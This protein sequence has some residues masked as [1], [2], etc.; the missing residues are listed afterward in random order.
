MLSII[1]VGL[2]VVVT[3]IFPVM[4]VAQKLGAEKTELI[5]CIL[6]IVVGGIVS[7][8]L[9]SFLPGSSTNEILYFLYSFLII[10][11][12]YKY[13]LQAN[14]FASV[15]IALISTLIKWAIIYVVAKILT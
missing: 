7:S 14:Y 8:I 1:I 4:F 3:S 5:D 6:A 11:V 13:M 9:V 10:G 12:V 15:L 2:F